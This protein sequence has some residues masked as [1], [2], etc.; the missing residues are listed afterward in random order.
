[1][2]E[3][4][5]GMRPLREAS[6]R[7]RTA[8]VLGDEALQ[9]ADA[10]PEELGALDGGGEVH[11]F[12]DFFGHVVWGAE[13]VSEVGERLGVVLFFGELPSLLLERGADLLLLSGRG[14]ACACVLESPACERLREED[15]ERHLLALGVVH[16]FEA[17]AVD[18]LRERV[19][20]LR[21]S[22][23]EALAV[24]LGLEGC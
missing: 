6:L 4:K 9:R 19:E 5:S 20:G 3:W 17:V 13:D 8:A 10:D 23:V 16:G 12:L 22:E 1:M 21:E 15:E 11:G 14:G 2:S 18:D 24:L 7:E